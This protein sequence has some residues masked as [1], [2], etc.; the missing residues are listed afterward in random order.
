MPMTRKAAVLAVGLAV[1]LVAGT[2]AVSRS[3][4]EPT[5]GAA[6]GFSPGGDFPLL[7]QEDLE[8]D[9]EAAASTGARWVRVDFAWSNVE[10]VPGAYD[11]S[12]VDRVTAAVDAVGMEV[13]ALPAYTP[14]WARPPGCTSNKCAPREAADFA[15][16]VAEAARRYGP[17]KVLAWELWNEPNIPAFW[18][19]APDVEAYAKLLRTSA[20]ALKQVRPDA[21][22]LSAGLSPAF[23]DGT[24]VAPVEFVERLY[25]LGALEQVDAVAVHPYSA[26]S[27]PLT[28]GTERWNTFL[29]MEQVHDVMTEHG[30]GDKPVW[31][32][33]FGVAT[34]NDPRATSERQQAAI[35]AQGLERLRDRTWPWFEVLL[36]YSLRDTADDPDDWQSGFGLLRHDGSRKPAFDTFAR[37]MRQP[38][39]QLP[40]SRSTALPRSSAD[41][42]AGAT[43]WRRVSRRGRGLEVPG[44]PADRDADPLRA[45]SPARWF[46]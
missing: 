30:D 25:A 6:S 35:V 15:R 44:A 26:T 7:S 2:A 45:T 27:L 42:T 38:L 21:M 5:L 11:W 46:A 33:E 4:P 16:F 17:D 29:Q 22:V 36:A 37:A 23:S 1:A 10:R 39:E 28:Q 32:T 14:E 9:L 8:R 19:P 3:E 40:S 43:A 12:D 24:S 20:A 13:L 41:V 34:G 18:K 31:G